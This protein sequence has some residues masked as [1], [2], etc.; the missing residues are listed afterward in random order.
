[1]TLKL[2]FQKQA[3]M[4]K[5][6][7]ALLP[8]LAAGVF[9]FGWRTLAIVLVSLFSCI[10]TEWLFVRKKNGK[11]TE[12]ILVT[13]LLLGL[14]MPPLVP[15]WM[16][17]LAG[18]FGVTFGKMAFGGF[19]MNIFNPAIVGRAFVY[20][21][22]PVQLAN[23]WIPAATFKAFPG[24]FMAWTYTIS[25][26]L[27]DAITSATPLSAF[28]DNASVVP[29]YW[30]L[31]I[32]NISGQFEKM[33]EMTLIGGGSVG[34]TSAMLLT[35]GGMFLLYKKIA[36]WKPVVSFFSSFLLLQTIL[37]Y[38]SPEK[39]A[40]PLFG[41]LSGAMVFAGFYMITDPVSMTK[42]D[43]GRWIYGAIAG[44]MTVVIRSYSL[45]AGGITFAILLANM[46]GPIVDY[47]VK[48]AQKRKKAAAK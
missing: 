41:L 3:P 11:V 8:A 36:N 5:V 37:H 33:G 7:Y 32:G 24:G 1:M 30:Q 16:V 6:S 29:N 46:F 43:I 34:E 31:F 21:T 19:G 38:V 23:Q 45:F 9:F 20:I 4:R 22:F 15:L 13:A 17:A 48:A 12:A 40:D 42:T 28:R 18:I 35:L 44:T 26:K 2:K 10:L 27:S 39:V 25:G 47:Y 14:S